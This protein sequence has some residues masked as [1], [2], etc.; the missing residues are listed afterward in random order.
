MNKKNR[1]MF[2][3]ANH[4][5]TRRECEIPIPADDEVLIK[6]EANGICG[7]DIHFYSEG[8]LG[9]FIVTEPYIPGH[10]AAGTIAGKGSKV[11]GFSE[12]EKVV[13]EPGIPCGRCSFCLGGRYNLC[14]SVVFLSAPPINGTF[15]DY[16]CVR[17]DFVYKLPDNMPF[18]HGALAEPAAVAVH[19]VNRA[20]FINGKDG[21]IL[22]AGPIGLLTLQAFKAAGGGKAICVDILDSRLK[23][24][25]ELG[26]DETINAKNSS[27]LKELADIVFETAGSPITT[28]QLFTIARAGGTVVQ[29]GWPAGNT[30]NMNI[31]DLLDKELTY[32]GVNRYA[33]AYSAAIRY[34]CDGR[35]NVKQ[36]ITHVFDFDKTP[37][38][39]SFAKNNP[40]QVVKVIV[41]N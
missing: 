16:I 12:G 6:V 3:D 14:P 40:N 10:E 39:F 22:G 7:S 5:F 36:L 35:I 33:N 23:L 34:I 28:A 37:E 15:C 20:G 27:V 4:E 24:S 17:A 29:V 11:T 2:L 32:I 41:K 19:A 8:R 9:N 1:S 31:A 30:V 13:I 18:E 26:A 38:A 25:K 21:L